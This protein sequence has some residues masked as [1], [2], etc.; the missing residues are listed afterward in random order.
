VFTE[1]LL[2]AIFFFPALVLAK[3]KMRNY[4]T[5]ALFSFL[6][7]G[8]AGSAVSTLAFTTAFSLINPSLVILL[9]KLQ[10]VLVIF[11]SAA[12]LKEKIDSSFYI[13]A[14]LAMAGGFL[15]SYPDLAPLLQRAEPGQGVMLGYFLTLLAVAGWA[16][17]T[18]FGK[19]L[20]SQGF[21]ERQIMSGRFFFGFWALLIYCLFQSS[22]PN[23]STTVD[24]YL[25]ILIMVLLSGI[26]GMFFYYKGL[27]LLS[28]H[29]A[30]IAEMFFPVSAVLINWI[31]LGKALHNIQILGAIILIAASFGINKKRL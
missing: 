24:S 12:L 10:P 1:H 30:S 14:V 11:L 4:G 18:V 20:F 22:L 15:I 27:K 13:F 29:V 28:A 8:V 5:S 21:T 25:K 17:A 2:L 19:K 23:A 31:F 3:K 6:V 16:S 9:Q 26:A 7:I